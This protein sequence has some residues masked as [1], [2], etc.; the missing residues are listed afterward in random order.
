MR[1]EEINPIDGERGRLIAEEFMDEFRKNPKM[2]DT[3]VSE[4]VQNLKKKH[5]Y[6]YE[7]RVAI[8]RRPD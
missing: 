3:D 1:Y 5:G 4:L 6:E 2:T 8:N 7:F